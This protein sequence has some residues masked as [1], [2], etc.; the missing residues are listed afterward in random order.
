MA[1]PPAIANN[2][3]IFNGALGSPGL[4]EMEHGVEVEKDLEFKLHIHGAGNILWFCIIWQEFDAGL[5]DL[6]KNGWQFV[7]MQLLFIIWDAVDNFN[8][9]FIAW[10]RKILC[11]I[12]IVTFFLIFKNFLKILQENLKTN[13]LRI[14]FVYKWDFSKIIVKPNH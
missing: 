4:F 6:N 1:N 5:S 14:C 3:N 2:K 12:N 10:G 9:L 11:T 7:W 13:Q 8:T